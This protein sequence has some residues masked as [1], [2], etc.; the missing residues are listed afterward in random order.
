MA[1]NKNNDL[2]EG[3]FVTVS[4]TLTG[5]GDLKGYVTDI[6]DGFITVQYNMESSIMANG[7][8]GIVGLPHFF[9]KD[10]K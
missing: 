7:D 10:E 2:K 1:L 5:Y 9:T 8:K 6:G 4:G 3:D